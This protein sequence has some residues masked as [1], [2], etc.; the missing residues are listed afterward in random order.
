MPLKGKPKGSTKR[1][2]PSRNPM[3]DTDT[4]PDPG[5]MDTDDSTHESQ[6]SSGSHG[7]PLTGDLSPAGSGSAATGGDT[8]VAASARPSKRVKTEDLTGGAVRDTSSV[9]GPGSGSATT[10]AQT[11]LAR[12]HDDLPAMT[13]VRMQPLVTLDDTARITNLQISSQQRT[14][15]PFGGP[16][17][18]HTVAWSAIVD[19]IRARMHGQPID[20]AIDLLGNAQRDAEGWMSQPDSAGMKLFDMLPDREQRVGPLENWAWL[21]ATQLAAAKTAAAAGDTAK[22]AAELQKAIANH[23]AYLNYLPFATVLAASAGG[24]KGSTENWKRQRILE[25]E[26]RGEPKGAAAL[27]D[28]DAGILRDQLWG[29]FAFDAALRESDASLLFTDEVAVAQAELTTLNGLSK[30]LS[31]EIEWQSGPTRPALDTEA[32]R[33]EAIALAARTTSTSMKR[34]AE[35][36]RDSATQLHTFS[37]VT[38][39]Q[40]RTKVINEMQISVLRGTADATAEVNELVTRE[41]NA[42]PRAALMLAELVHEHQ[43]TAAAAYPRAVTV[44]HFLGRREKEDTDAQ[45]REK[46]TAAALDKIETEII[47]AFPKAAETTPLTDLMKAVTARY[48]EITATPTPA[49]ANSWTTDSS[50]EELVVTY[51]PAAAVPLTVNGRAA[52]PTGV[53]GM[54]SHTTAWTV[55]VAAVQALVSKATSAEEAIGALAE[56]T[57]NDLDSDVMKL[58]WLLPAD[59]LEAGQLVDI[60]AQAEAVLDTTDVAEAATAFLSFRNLLPFA[61]LDAGGRGGKGERSTRPRNVNFD[62]TSLDDAAELIHEALTNADPKADTRAEAI[63]ALTSAADQLAKIPWHEEDALKK[64]A[65]DTIKRLRAKVNLLK[66]GAP[67]DVAGIIRSTR[68]AEHARVT[69]Q[70]AGK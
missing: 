44:S 53:A 63:A 22:A 52:A 54:G 67:D 45:S 30:R 26:K 3:K 64:P 10:A 69:R 2:T 1:K 18:D 36:I 20:K 5:R 27:P 33:T 25:V 60:F 15:S 17:G 50:N 21:T 47:A 41:I 56:E 66:K 23:L 31:Y 24:S 4:S 48:G 16:M 7:G 65:E 43:R 19:S 9:S 42:L 51:D 49:E 14:P 61:T 58:D 38:N 29:L 12:R 13:R 11:L 59:Q 6:A 35:R 8:G 32:I 46:A 28:T 39:K 62:D 68:A 34:A 37:N 40:S 55:E 57:L 70:A